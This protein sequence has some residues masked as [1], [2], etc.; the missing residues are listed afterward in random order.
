MTEYTISIVRV[1]HDAV[2]ALQYDSE[3]KAQKAVEEMTRL[4][5]ENG[6]LTVTVTLSADVASE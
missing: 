3:H 2:I 1:G 5:R 4:L 6:K